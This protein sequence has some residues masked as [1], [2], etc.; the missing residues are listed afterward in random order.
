[1]DHTEFIDMCS[2]FRP[3]YIPPNR[4]AIA[5]KW[6]NIVF[7]KENTKCIKELKYEMVCLTLDGWSNVRNEPIV[8]AC[9]VM[10][11]ER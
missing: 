9:I 3:G 1:M 6:L 8:C 2:K 4:K 11:K 10:T 7:E 5:D